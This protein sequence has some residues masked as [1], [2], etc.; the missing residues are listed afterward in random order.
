MR[1]HTEFTETT[2]GPEQEA[3]FTQGTQQDRIRRIRPIPSLCTL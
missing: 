3:D 1:F 2:E